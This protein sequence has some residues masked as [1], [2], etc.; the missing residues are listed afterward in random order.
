VRLD[1][2]DELEG[3]LTA[4]KDAIRGHGGGAPIVVELAT[5][6]FGTVQVAAGDDY[7]VKITPALIEKLERVLGTDRVAVS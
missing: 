7:R 6:Q 2:G 4:V 1:G 3:Q 5:P